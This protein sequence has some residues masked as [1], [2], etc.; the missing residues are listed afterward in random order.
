[1]QQLAQTGRC[2]VYVTDGG[3]CQDQGAGCIGAGQ[4]TC[5]RLGGCASLDGRTG[6]RGRI[7]AGGILALRRGRRERRGCISLDGRIGRHRRIGLYTCI[8]LVKGRR[9][10]SRRIS[11]HAANS[12]TIYDAGVSQPQTLRDALF[13]K[14]FSARQLALGSARHDRLIG[15]LGVAVLV[16]IAAATRLIRL[17]QPHT[18]VFDETFYVKD[19]WSLSQVGFEA[20]WPANANPSFE[21]GETNIF[22]PN[23]AFVVHPQ[24]GK[25]LISLGMQLF[26]PQYAFSWRLVN[27]LVGIAAVVLMARIGRRLFSSTVMGLTAGLLMAIDGTA[28]VHSRTA[29]LDQHLMFFALLAFGCLLLDRDLARRRLV[30]ALAALAHNAGQQLPPS[31]AGDPFPWPTPASL[32]LKSPGIGWRRLLYWRWWRFAAAVC[33]GL[34]VGVKW[35]GL[36]FVAVFGLMTVLW[37]ISARRRLGFHNWLRVG[38]AYDGFRAFVVMIPTVVAVYVAS[39]FSWFA[40]PGAWGRQW[41]VENPGAGLTWLPDTLRSFVEYHGRMWDFHTGLDAHH[42]YAAH[43]LGFIVQ[44]RPTAFFWRD[45]GQGTVTHITSLG[46]PLLWWLAALA[47]VAVVWLGVS[48]ADWRALAVLSG[49][50]AGWLPWLWHGGRTIFTFYVI[51]FTPWVIFTL[52]YPAVIALERTGP[53]PVRALV[54]SAGLA[55]GAGGGI[56]CAGRHVVTRFVTSTGPVVTHRLR[57]LTVVCI[58]TVLALIVLVSALYYPVWAGI[59]IPSHYWNSIM[60]LRSWV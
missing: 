33:L 28:I 6:R 1:M 48:R 55:R 32:R 36:Y 37:D 58:V 59:P 3:T 30:N 15:W 42:P 26:G 24:V 34:A 25:W 14:V 43:P 12:V 31:Q 13:L 2:I 60:L 35:S 5:I 23:A 47:I 49:T 50:I 54:R 44:W 40:T 45:S 9:N 46:N 8:D 22:L 20:Q 21:A 18:L 41:A 51:A 52:L 57:A 27:A 38:L 17:G 19:A 39:W 10:R 11:C 4:R 53:R 56:A 16:V 7:A 29:L